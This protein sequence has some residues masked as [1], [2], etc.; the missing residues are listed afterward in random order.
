MRRRK[1]MLVENEA[2]D[3]FWPAFTDLTSTIALILFV[4]VL[5]AYIQN[6]LNTR[7][8]A[9][10]RAQLVATMER[11]GAS[12]QEVTDAEKRLR[13]LAAE[14]EAGQSQLRLSE[15]KVQQQQQVISES[16]R[17]LSEVRAQLRGIAVLRLSML[18]KVKNS[19]EAEL[20]KSDKQAPQASIGEN[21]NI[22][23]DESLLFESNSY[24]IKPDGK[25]FLDSLANAL[26]KVL[27]DPQVRTNIDVV[28][29]QGHTDHRGTVTYNRELSARRANAV[30]DYLFQTRP[31]LGKDYGRYF[32]SSAYSEF[33]PI[34]P[35]KSEAA[36]RENR[37][38]EIS[39]VLRD[40]KV[41]EVIDDYMRNIDDALRVPHEPAGHPQAPEA[42]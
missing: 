33:R 42:P 20:K 15:T 17:E 5:L 12:Q 14:I 16:N 29:V 6:L 38:I 23:L 9:R 27:S 4:L 21:G 19:I 31:T 1:R 36:M 25:P 26:L 7:N 8:L 34:N 18:Q 11:L 10:A 2:T 3:N 28:L 30:L 22:V 40:A 35:G 37:R 24:T 13:Q 32:A 41:R 39:V